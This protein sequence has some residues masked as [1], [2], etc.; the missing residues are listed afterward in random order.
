MAKGRLAFFE[1]LVLRGK[2]AGRG[3]KRFAIIED[4]KIAHVQVY[5]ARRAL[6]G[7]DDGVG[8]AVEARAERNAATTSQSCVREAFV[9]HACI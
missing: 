1:V 4:G 6:V 7:D 3:T 5:P 2:N 9:R 8:T